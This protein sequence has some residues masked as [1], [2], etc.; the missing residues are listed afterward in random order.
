MSK[1]GITAIIISILYIISMRYT[2]MSIIACAK[3]ELPK[4]AAQQ[5]YVLLFS[6]VLFGYFLYLNQLVTITL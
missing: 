1:A 4:A 6:T 3:A 5:I 2:T